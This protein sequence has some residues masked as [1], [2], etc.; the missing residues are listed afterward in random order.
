MKTNDPSKTIII[1]TSAFIAGFNPF[2]ISNEQFSVPEVGKE[3]RDNS[4]SKLRFE[5][6]AESGKLTVFKPD[7][8]FRNMVNKYSKEVGD[9]NFLS[10]ADMQI[11][12]LA[13]QL[14][15]KNYSIKIITDDYSIQNVA[16]KINVDFA[17]VNT[18]GIR[19]LFHWLLY[20]PG[21]R[22]K[23]AANYKAILCE[24]CG[25]KLKRKP[26]TKTRIQI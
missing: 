25:T 21:C 10:E 8:F 23:Y 22:K 24:I 18:M 16:K 5:A 13:L 3:L 26:L 1:D 9:V 7:T 20:C 12:A 17:S 14:K 19:F 11:L 15:E 6:A 2:V 4:F